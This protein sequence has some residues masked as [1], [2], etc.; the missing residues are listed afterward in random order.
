M[1]PH[2]S[3]GEC[4]LR[5]DMVPEPS[6][7]EREKAA[8]SQTPEG[9]PPPPQRSLLPPADEAGSHPTSQQRSPEL[10]LSSADKG[11]VQAQP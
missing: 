5:E 7:E 3:K 4:R 1:R 2:V 8:R 9:W 10:A 11:T 6:L